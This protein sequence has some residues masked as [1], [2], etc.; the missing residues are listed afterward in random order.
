MYDSPQS[1]RLWRRYKLRVELL[2]SSVSPSVRRELVSD[3]TA[4]V[5]DMLA[6]EPSDVPENER[7]AAA[8]KRLGDPK[9]FVA[10][11]LAD[12]VFRDPPGDAG[13]IAALRSLGA[14]AARGWR[15]FIS[16]VFVAVASVSS[17]GMLILAAGGLIWPDRIGIFEVSV[18]NYQA[19]I[20]GS[21]QAYGEALLWPWLS[22]LLA[23][24]GTMLALFAWRRMHR[25]LAELITSTD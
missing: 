24:V 12:A 5:R 23:I 2:L 4:H 8:L 7:L 17:V 6:S 22:V 25:L 16:S 9:E 3:L 14:Y 21:T 1:R 18:D 10:P 19:R 11:L 15:F 13:V 20:L